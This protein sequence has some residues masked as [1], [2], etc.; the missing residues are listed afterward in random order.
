MTMQDVIIA[1]QWLFLIYFIGLNGG[2]IV[3]NLIA[4]TYLRHYRRARSVDGLPS[5]YSGMELPISVLVPAYNESATIGDSVRALLQLVYPEFEIVV[6]N[7]GS[8]DDTLETLTE[9]FSLVPFPEAY[10]VRIETKPIRGL[11]RS[12]LYPRLRVIDKENGGKADALNA[13]INSARYP[14]FCSVDADS[15]LQRD[16]L[17]RVMR[18]FVEDPLTVATGGTIRIANGCKVS[19]GFI[20]GIDLPRNPLALLQIAEYLRAFLFGRL[21][22]S[23][24]NAL[25]IISGAFG[26]FRKESVVAVG[27]YRTDTVGEDMELI[28]RLHRLLR[29][30]GRPYRITFVPDPIC[31]TDAP[32]DLRTLARQRTRWQ[33][34]LVESLSMNLGLCFHPKGGTAGWLAFPFMLLFEFL[35][36]L[37]EVTGVV[38]VIVGFWQGWLSYTAFVAF[39]LV[40]I[41]MGVLLSA[42]AILL[43]EMSFHIYPRIK[44]TLVLFLFGTL[45]NLGYRQLN[46]VWRAIGLMGWMVGGRARW[47]EMR[48][49]AS[50]GQR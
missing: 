19:D 42:S 17:Q 48:R 24:L 30:R 25:L 2:Y 4:I 26:L 20:E 12:T 22:W 8:T 49:T 34:G 43:E 35:G 41:G 31:W 18:P 40:A 9:E 47:G 45:E 13:G 1:A 16:S 46:A 3:L 32:E 11:Y 7:D 50:W 44:H 28:V 23:P 6:I 37:L 5:I 39:L 27:G 14:L 33:R 38:F 21:G 15:V 36:P 10:R 29:K